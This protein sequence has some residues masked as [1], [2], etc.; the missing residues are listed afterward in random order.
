MQVTEQKNDGLKRTFSCTIPAVD[1]DSAVEAELKKLGKNVKIAGFRPG[2]VPVKILQQRYGKSVQSDVVR[3][4]ITNGVTRAINDNKLRP[5]LAPELAEQDYEEGKDLSFSFNVEVLPDVPE[6]AFEEI[7]LTREIFEIADADIDDALKR[8]AER[9]PMP[10]AL[11]A[12]AK[13][14]SGHVVSMDFAGKLDGVLF[15]G[16]SAQQYEVEIGSHSLIEGFEEQ[17]IGLKAGDEKQVIVTFPENYFNKELASKEATFD[18]TVHTV[19]KLEAPVVDEKFAKDRGFSDLRALKEAVRD[20]MGKEFGAIIRSHMKRNLFDQLEEKVDFPIPEGMFRLEFD[21]IWQKLQQA[22]EQGDES[23]KDKTEEELRE[24]YRTIAERRV[25]LGILLAE[26]GRKQKLSVSRDEL[27][28]ALVQYAG[29]FQ[30]QE[31]RVLEYYKANPERLDEF[32][33]PIL[34]E[35]AVD[36]IF[37]KIQYQDTPIT[38]KELME[39]EEAEAETGEKPA[40]KPKAKPKA[41]PAAKK[42]AEDAADEKPAATK[43]A[44]KK[45]PAKAK[46]A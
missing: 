40:V 23:L 27:T 4:L 17:L 28:R 43:P 25:R 30:G 33:G 31:Q 45:K 34:E 12:D 38:A 10:V 32:R 9:S 42:T 18:V 14:E 46:E 2:H 6:I 44:A 29:N 21:S 39:R 20:Q 8:L 7:T 24:E 16:G 15:D 35:K 26:L 22:Q 1:I 41:R 36:W 19:S 11:P 5:A 3:N 37:G 13:A